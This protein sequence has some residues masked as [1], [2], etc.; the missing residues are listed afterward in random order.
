LV[1]IIN[2]K[3]SITIIIYPED[4]VRHIDNILYLLYDVSADEI[5]KTLV[6]RGKYLSKPEKRKPEEYIVYQLNNS[7]LIIPIEEINNLTE[8]KYKIRFEKMSSLAFYR[9]LSRMK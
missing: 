5:F 7:N 6:F 2:K 4:E 3:K 8:S 9:K 1:Q